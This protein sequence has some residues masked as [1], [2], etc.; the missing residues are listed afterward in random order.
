MTC[1]K[2]DQ[3][4]IQDSLESHKGP[5]SSLPIQAQCNPEVAIIPVLI[6]RM[7]KLKAREVH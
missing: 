2:S 5:R 7:R 1:D 3:R 6:L 4:A